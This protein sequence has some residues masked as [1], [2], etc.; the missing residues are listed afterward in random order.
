MGAK[1]A[2]VIQRVSIIFSGNTA[3]DDNYRVKPV[4]CEFIFFKLPPSSEGA[5]P[6]KNKKNKNKQKTPHQN[7][8]MKNTTFLN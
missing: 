1:L 7:T 3:Q 2:I 5:K 4:T 8:N 6:N